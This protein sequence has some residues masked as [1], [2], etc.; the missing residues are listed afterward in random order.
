MQL[1]GYSAAPEIRCPDGCGRMAAEPTVYD[2]RSTVD[3]PS[4]PAWHLT[5]PG[6]G[7]E[8]WIDSAGLPFWP[9]RKL[10]MCR[11]RDHIGYQ[12]ESDVHPDS[13]AE[14]AR[15]LILNTRLCSSRAAVRTRQNRYLRDPDDEDPPTPFDTL[16]ATE[17]KAHG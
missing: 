6:C 3:V 12:T 1:T 14:L 7:W 4:G 11:R 15:R 9:R 16:R 2:S 10:R 17:G 13:R 5:C 8:V